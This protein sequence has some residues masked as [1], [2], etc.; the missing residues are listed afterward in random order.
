MPIDAVAEI[1]DRKRGKVF[2]VIEAPDV[3]ASDA[4]IAPMPPVEGD[5]PCAFNLSPEALVLKRA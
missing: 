2:Q 5:F 4:G 1:V 3:S